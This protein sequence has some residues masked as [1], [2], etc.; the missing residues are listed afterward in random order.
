MQVATWPCLRLGCPHRRDT[1][2]G[3]GQWGQGLLR[4]E[5]YQLATSNRSLA[6]TTLLPPCRVIVNLHAAPH[7][8]TRHR[9]RFPC[10][11]R[12]GAVWASLHPLLP[13][14]LSPRPESAQAEPG[15]AGLCL[16]SP[17]HHKRSSRVSSMRTRS[18]PHDRTRA[19][20]HS[21]HP[22]A[23]IRT[24]QSQSSPAPLRSERTPQRQQDAG[25]RVPARARPRSKLVTENGRRDPITTGVR[26][27]P[28]R[29]CAGPPPRRRAVRAP[30]SEST[31]RRC[32][33]SDVGHSPPRALERF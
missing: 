12:G 24:P 33:D 30:V 20:S 4:I 27:R 11:P 2:E 22:R 3:A 6:S 25:I 13:L 26:S 15:G 7:A 19:A 14:P 1:L 16:C 32:R 9:Q 18:T 23:A 21:T 28:R 5:Q 31:G 17:L 8:P 29:P 10:V